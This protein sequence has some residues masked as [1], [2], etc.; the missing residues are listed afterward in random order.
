MGNNSA[1][2]ILGATSNNKPPQNYQST[3]QQ[4]SPKIWHLRYYQPWFDLD[5]F[6]AL[7]RLKRAIMPWKQDPF[8]LND[9]DLPDLYC[10]FWITVTLSFLVAAVSN[11]ARFLSAR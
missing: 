8:F 4:G 9:Q 2:P 3:E 7:D 5:T 6:L 10:P 11:M 1:E